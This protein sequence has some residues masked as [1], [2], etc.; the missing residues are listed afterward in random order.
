MTTRAQ[1]DDFVVSVIDSSLLDMSIKWIGKNLSP[2]EV[3]KD[4]D[5]EFWAVNNGYVLKE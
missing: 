1:D 2:E 5:L 4:A 3:F